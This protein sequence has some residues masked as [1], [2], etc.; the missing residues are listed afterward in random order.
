MNGKSAFCLLLALLLAASLLSGCTSREEKEAM[1]R[2]VARLEAVAL[3]GRAVDA[4]NAA[5]D[6][7]EAKIAA[8]N[9]EVEAIRTANADF[10]AAVDAIQARLDTEPIPYDPE[11][12]TALEVAV[13]TARAALQD[14]PDTLTAAEERLSCADSL[15]A[16]EAAELA[17]RA[18][19]AA[20]ELRARALPELVKP[21]YSEPLAGIDAALT[22]Y[23]ESLERILPVIAPTDE[24]VMERL[25]EVANIA[26][27]N[28]VTEGHDP[29]G[30][31]GKDGGYIGCVFF[32]DS[33]ISPWNFR[34][35]P[36]ADRNDPVDVGTQGGGSVEIYQ[37]QAEAAAR[38]TFLNFNARSIGAFGV[39]GS[40]VVRVS[41]ELSGTDQRA[42]RDAILEALLPSEN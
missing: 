30:N 6:A 4:Y 13:E 18:D 31:L 16:Q 27:V 36:G 25:M 28:A 23:E 38:E 17:A 12:R 21:D 15:S 7:Y 2:E 42:L 9:G 41:D 40:V 32:R 8:F 22:P 29:N 35:N 5:V 11:T 3:A 24:Y 34:L 10:A 20:Q 1:E 26:A 39:V 37:T 19:S 33:R 14:D